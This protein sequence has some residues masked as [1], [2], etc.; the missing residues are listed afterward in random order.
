MKQVDVITETVI[1][2]PVEKVAA[3]SADPDNA[4]TWYRNIKSAEWKTAKPLQKGSRI[5]FNAQFMGKKLAYTYEVTE[6]IPDKKL[7][8]RTADGPFP[9]ETTYTWERIH[10]NA[11]KMTLRNAGHPSG[12][13]KLFSPLMAR[14][15]RKANAKDLALLKKILEG[16]AAE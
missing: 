9:M 12:F 6:Y 11:T 3:F 5:A 15:M 1:N 10:E 13:S 2:F 16:K 4:T 14:M 7:V 8:M